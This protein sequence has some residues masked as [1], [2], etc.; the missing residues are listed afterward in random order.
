VRKTFAFLVLASL[1]LA[2]GGAGKMNDA[3]RDYLL[4][5]LEQSKKAMLASI[6]GL[7]DAQWRFK[8]APAVW[9]VQEC[10]EHIVLAEDLLLSMAQQSLKSPAVERP[11]TANLDYYKG[12]AA[13]VQDRSQKAKAPEPLV[14]SQRFATPDDAAREFIARR[15]KT[16]AYIKDSKDDLFLHI[17][18][19]PAGS[20]DTYQFL[21]LLAAHSARHTAQIR[22][23]QSNAGYPKSDKAKFL[24]VYELAHGTPDQLT[25]AQR[26]ILQQH[27][28]YLKSLAEK[29]VLTW[30]GRTNN[31]TQPRGYAELAATESEAKAYIDNDPAVKAGIFKCTVESFTEVV[32]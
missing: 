13:K 4:G 32:H 11:A 7:S 17:V 12:F 23:V 21:V 1:P 3:E 27:S 19:G 5:Q 26:A 24:A 9:S 30:A 25:P 14:P 29:G 10:A 6:N 31:P 8:S 15:E 16:I 2:A 28:A 18:N 20:M 22:E